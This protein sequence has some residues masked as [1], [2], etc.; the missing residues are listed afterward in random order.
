VDKLSVAVGD[1]VAGTSSIVVV[2]VEE[3]FFALPAV[4]DECCSMYNADSGRYDNHVLSEETPE[5][6]QSFF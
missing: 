2:V 6:S 5:K 1:K 4:V 3:D